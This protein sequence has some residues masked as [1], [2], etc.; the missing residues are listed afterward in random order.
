M[1]GS[2]TFPKERSARSSASCSRRTFPLCDLNLLT[3]SFR[4]SVPALLVQ[5]KTIVL[6]V[7]DRIFFQTLDHD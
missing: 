4:K 7:S 5:E 6:L 1:T 2:Y 3:V